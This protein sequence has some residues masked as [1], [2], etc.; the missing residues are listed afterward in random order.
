MSNCSN[1]RHLLVGLYDNEPWT[2]VCAL[3]DEAKEPYDSCAQHESI[4][5]QK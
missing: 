4:Q 2:C 1:C 3:D 5:E